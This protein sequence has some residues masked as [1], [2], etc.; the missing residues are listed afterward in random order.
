[1][2]ERKREGAP[3]ILAWLATLFWIG[4]IFLFLFL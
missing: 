2:A 1:M 3:S 4:L